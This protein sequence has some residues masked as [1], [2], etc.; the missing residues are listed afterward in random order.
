MIEVQNCTFIAVKNQDGED[1]SQVC[2]YIRAASG[3]E[4]LGLDFDCNCKVVVCNVLHEP[5]L[6]DIC[7][8]WSIKARFR[9]V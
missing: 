4:K 8:H 1:H 7:S 6:N 3:F 9:N 2:N 5:F